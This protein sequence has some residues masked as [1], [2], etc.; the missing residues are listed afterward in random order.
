MGPK[1]NVGCVSASVVSLLGLSVE[2]S[3]SPSGFICFSCLWVLRD[4]NLALEFR[5]QCW[6][7][8]PKERVTGAPFPGG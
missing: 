8:P 4:L 2:V 1:G 7:E 3:V 5:D 6:Q